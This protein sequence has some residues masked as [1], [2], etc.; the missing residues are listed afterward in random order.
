MKIV[1]V[2]ARTLPGKE[3]T[4]G[5]HVIDYEA[6]DEAGNTEKCAFQIT[7]VQYQEEDNRKMKDTAVSDKKRIQM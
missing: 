3:F 2:T 1:Q 6:T 4:L 7:V 5:K